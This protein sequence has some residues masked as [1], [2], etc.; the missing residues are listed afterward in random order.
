MFEFEEHDKVIMEFDERLFNIVVERIVV[1]A[2]GI[3]VE[4]NI[5]VLK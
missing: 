4:F 2:S 1:R 5:N 3:K